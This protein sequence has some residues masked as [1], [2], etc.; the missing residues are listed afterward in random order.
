MSGVER[1]AIGAIRRHSVV[2]IGNAYDSGVQGRLLAAQAIG[3]TPPIE[4]FMMKLEH[5]ENLIELLD[6]FQY[7]LAN[8]RMQLDQTELFICKAARFLQNR[9]W[10][11]DL[12]DVVKLSARPDEID[13][14][15]SKSHFLC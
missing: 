10:N 13:L 2:R 4:V 11:S 8:L 7:S 6:F 5:R 15:G 9:I 1:A 3:V 14:L 12:P